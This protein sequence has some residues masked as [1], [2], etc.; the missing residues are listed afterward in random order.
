MHHRITL[1]IRYDQPQEAWDATGKVYEA[2]PGWLSAADLPRWFGTEDATEFVWASVEPGGVV[3]EAQMDQA[4]WDDWLATLC[5]R[6]S[7]A[8]GRPIHDAE[9]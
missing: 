9:M 6:L 2:M 5:A 3:F 7:S 1:N 8:L 4:L